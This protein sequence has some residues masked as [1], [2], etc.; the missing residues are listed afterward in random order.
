MF[1]SIHRDSIIGFHATNQ[2]KFYK[3]AKYA[4][5]IILKKINSNWKPII[6]YYFVSS[7]C[8]SFELM[9][10]MFIVIRRAKSIGFNI[11][12]VSDPG[13]YFLILAKTLGYLFTALFHN[14]WK[15]YSI[16]VWLPPHLLKS[17]RNIFFKHNFQI[18]D[19]QT[20]K[21]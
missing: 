16:Y 8:P 11:N 14:R 21:V 17:T 20:N 13:A 6:A 3:P 10:I 2:T 1:Y 4:L 19:K 18:N 9:D 15:K 7:S 5:V 12:V